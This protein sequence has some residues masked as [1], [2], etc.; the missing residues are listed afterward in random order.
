MI[1]LFGSGRR[2]GLPDASPFVVKAEVLLKMSGL[3]YRYR[4]VDPRRAP[5]GKIPYIEEDG[6]KLG[7]S[8]FIRW[9]LEQT[10]GVDFSGGYG[11]EQQAVAW[12]F[13]KLCEDHLY[14]AMVHLRW[15][16]EANF[17]RGPRQFFQAV[18]LPLRAFVIAM[19]RRKVRASLNSQGFGRHSAGEIERLAGADID[20]L[21]VF[22]G[23]KPFLL[24]E[25]PCGADATLFAFIDGLLCRTFESPIRTAVAARANLVAYRNRMAIKYYPDGVETQAKQAPLASD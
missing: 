1:T 16:D 24:G 21:S 2:M 6:R 3:P 10:H 20:A 11:P 5:K 18:P 14:W 23:D 22:L 8:V 13:E 12:A 7:D 15:A 9:H 4:A 17:N 19:V 25:R